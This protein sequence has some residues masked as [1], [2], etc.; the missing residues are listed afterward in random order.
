MIA[1][2]GR[3]SASLVCLLLVVLVAAACGAPD[4][5]EADDD[6]DVAEDETDEPD[7]E[8]DDDEPD[9]A[10]DRPDSLVVDNSFVLTTADPGRQW[11]PTGHT[12][13]RALYDT[14][15]TFEAGD[16]SEPVPMLVDD[17]EMDDDAEHFTFELRDDVTFTDGS[18]L[19]ADDVEF[20]LR[21][22]RNL[23]GSGS[24]LLE[25][26]ERIEAVDD[27]TVEMETERPLPTLISKLTSPALGIVNR[28]E[29]EAAGGTAEEGADQD[30][31][32]EAHLNEQSAGSGP[33]ELESF[34]AEE[35]VVFTRND[36]YWGEVPEFERIVLRN[37]ETETQRLNIQSGES[38]LV[39]DLA[40][41]DLEEVDEAGLQ[42][43]SDAAPDSWVMSAN[44]DEE[45]SP[46]TASPE[47]WEAV[48]HGLDYE[49]LVDFAGPDT[50]FAPSVIGEQF[51]GA[52]PQDEV[53]ERDLD[54]VEE[55]L[56]A[57]G[58]D[59]EDVELTYPSDINF[60]GLAFEPVAEI[61]Q[62][63]LD[64]AGL[65][66]VLDPAPIETFLERDRDGDTEL[67]LSPNAPNFPD[68]E[69]YLTFMPGA[70]HGERAGWPED[71]APAVTEVGDA[72]RVATDDDREEAYRE[73]QRALQEESPFFPLFQPA[74]ALVADS[75][76]T[77]V[78]YDSNWRVNLADLGWE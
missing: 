10:G 27:L 47:F 61:V 13:A 66:V 8:P 59:G 22:Q 46:V 68:P 4:D 15:F 37:V 54:R 60:N 44:A 31:E 34:S 42:V 6:A 21:R 51:L 29:V 17:W 73:W 71:A 32:A 12:V 16:V 58:Y 62:S 28:E 26:V 57:A 24:F 2:L 20:S 7:D 41:R 43:D 52:L 53:P 49:E 1:L 69:A 50:R 38:H 30:D 33:F 19:T 14:L 11:E 45:L 40:G 25:E 56:D 72:A 74:E 55:S 9:D 67:A 63:Q 5:D 36:D 23:L 3:R 35:Q 77:G 39:L 48:R 75:S 78:V 70:L 76:M 64:E 18:Q 65:S